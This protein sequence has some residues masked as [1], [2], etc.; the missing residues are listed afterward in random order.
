[1]ASMTIRN[2]DVD[3]K[4]RLRVRAARQAHSN[5][6]EAR[7]ILQQAVGRAT[8]PELLQRSR[9]L[10]AGPQGVDLDLPDRADDRVPSPIIE[11]TKV[12]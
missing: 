5:E 8:G 11:V 1:M 12:R 3:L 10:F 4:E 2:I 6:A 7:Q 9:E